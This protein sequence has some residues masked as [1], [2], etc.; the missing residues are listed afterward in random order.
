MPE[1]S[2]DW[3][4]SP[5]SNLQMPKKEIGDYVESQGFRVPKR[6]ETL[7][8]ALDEVFRGK[9]IIM[10]SEH[11]DEYDGPSGLMESH[12][13]G[14]DSIKKG[15]YNS[16]SFGPFSIDDEIPLTVG[17]NPVTFDREREKGPGMYN[18]LDVVMANILKVPAAQTIDRLKRLQSLH[19]VIRDYLKLTN[20]S[21]EQLFSQFQYSFW[22]YIPG[23]DIVMVAD[24]AID[25]RYH[26]MADDGT[27][28]HWQIS[29]DG[30]E[31][32]D[33]SPSDDFL[34]PEV[35]SGLVHDYEA[36]R[37]LPR[38]SSKHCPIMEMKIDENVQNCFLQYHR[39]LD[40]DPADNNLDPADFPASEGWLPAN[41][42]RGHIQSPMKLETA[43]HYCAGYGT[44]IPFP[45]IEQGSTDWSYNRA[46][47]ELMARHRTA[48]IHSG[49]TETLYL[50]LS[51]NHK[52]RSRW[53]KPRVA[54]SY[55][56]S[57]FH[58]LIDEELHEEVRRLVYR[59]H[60]M[61]RVVIDL[62]CDGVKGFVRLNPDSEQ[63]IVTDS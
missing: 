31:V 19:W 11:P 63:P 46:M 55:D 50:G 20:Q 38:F 21:A 24:S 42:V 60:R 48:Y 36:I 47:T 44:V 17:R 10:R 40:F 22:E 3:W 53:F 43:L 28:F 25:N 45:K 49:E 54:V 5:E 9:T 13:I 62:A 1:R 6:Y 4:L 16:I 15:F 57:E 35:T 56:R 39:T 12:V 2:T 23:P 14:Q 41:T 34:T 7:D 52:S 8:E 30:G 32:I 59:E 33:G 26:I 18:V 58:R 27:Y 61:A 51:D 29:G 37:N